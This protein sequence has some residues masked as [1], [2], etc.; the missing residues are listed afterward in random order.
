MLDKAIA[1]EQITPAESKPPRS[2]TSALL[3]GSGD[4]V[5][6]AWLGFIGWGAL[7]LIGY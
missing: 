1:A 4:L 2:Y 6:L 7:R 3:L 5:T